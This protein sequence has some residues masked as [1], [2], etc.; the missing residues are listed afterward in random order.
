MLQHLMF[1][2]NN[3]NTAMIRSSDAEHVVQIC[4]VMREWRGT[5]TN[6]NFAKLKQQIFDD[7]VCYSVPIKFYNL[8]FL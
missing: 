4:L 1:F 7:V 2:D 6:T 3:L 8:T 5:V